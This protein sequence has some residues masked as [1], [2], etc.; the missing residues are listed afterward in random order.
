MIFIT[1]MLL[2]YYRPVSGYLLKVQYCLDIRIK[3]LKSIHWVN[4][5]ARS[6]LFEKHIILTKPF[7]PNQSW[8]L[9]SF[10]EKD[11][12]VQYFLLSEWT[13]ISVQQILFLK[14]K[15]L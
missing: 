1:F 4:S 2:T 14:I 3:I 9:M 6:S 13:L 12:I 8:Q 5:S 11:I 7:Q 10:F 15:H